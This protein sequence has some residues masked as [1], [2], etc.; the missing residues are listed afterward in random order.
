MRLLSLFVSFLLLTLYGICI[1]FLLNQGDINDFSLNANQLNSEYDYI[2]VGGGSAGSVVASRL[3]QNGL[4]VLLLEAGGSDEVPEVKMP[5]GFGAIISQPE[6]KHLIWDHTAKFQK[7]NY[8][9]EIEFPR[10]KIIGGCGSINGNVWNKG[11]KSIYDLWEKKGAK[12][13]KYQDIEKYYEKAENTLWISKGGRFIHQAS[14]DVLNEAGKLFGFTEINKKQTGFGVY[15]TTMRNGRRWSTADAYLKPTLKKFGDKL[16]LSLNSTVNKI[17]FNEKKN[18]AVGVVLG[19]GKTIKAKK[20]VIL[21]AGAFG[22]PAILMRSGV[23][24]ST[25]L[26]NYGIEI[27]HDLPGVGKNLQDHPTTSF[28]VRTNDSR[29]DSLTGKPEPVSWQK[30]VDYLVFG[31]GQYSSNL[32]EVGGYIKTKYGQFKEI[33]DVQ[34]HCGAA[35]FPPKELA[36]EQQKDNRTENYIACA[37]T[38]VTARDKG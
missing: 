35:F 9:K 5:V 36:L 6:M 2:V 32:V 7:E 3:A 38:L 16:H 17:T 12:G 8:T 20:E 10:G 25:E 24:N 31:S 1:F 28:I 14:R 29:W 30:L 4:Q 23:G 26:K 37:V 34:I 15:E 11:S 33:D 27:T 19:N 21:S 22:S 18:R 13:W